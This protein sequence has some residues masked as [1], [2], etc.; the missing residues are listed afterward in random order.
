M[1]FT[2]QPA[3]GSQAAGAATPRRSEGGGGVGSHPPTRQP[4]AGGRSSSASFLFPSSTLQTSPKCGPSPFGP[5]SSLG[6]DGMASSRSSFGGLSHPSGAGLGTPFSAQLPPSLFTPHSSMRPASRAAQT[7]HDDQPP[8][9]SMLDLNEPEGA[10]A[11]VA[12][13]GATPYHPRGGR[14]GSTPSV[15]AEIASA[16][17]EST[18]EVGE[19]GGYW[20]TVFGFSG[21]SAGMLTTVLAWLRPSSRGAPLHHSPGVGPWIH[22]RF[23]S[24]QDQREALA[25]NGSVLHGCMLGVVEGVVPRGSMPKHTPTTQFVPI[26]L[27]S[28]RAASYT[29]RGALGRTSASGAGVP[30]GGMLWTL[31]E[32]LFG[33]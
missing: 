27:T 13:P 6:I 22:V 9:H 12:P 30:R 17:S 20:V 4:S 28:S 21:G 1:L 3:F 25:R 8:L 33:F 29:P 19:G 7:P 18:A 16:Y 10:G 23:E 32:Y 5:T 2:P 31:S 24:W 11:A 15:T 14:F 26:G